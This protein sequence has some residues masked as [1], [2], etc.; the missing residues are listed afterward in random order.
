M[1]Y[2]HCPS[3]WC[4]QIGHFDDVPQL[5]T[6]DWMDGNV[7]QCTLSLDPIFGILL[8]GDSQPDMVT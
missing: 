7:Q 6:Q 3:Y 4:P 5:L 2:V 8:V 1:G